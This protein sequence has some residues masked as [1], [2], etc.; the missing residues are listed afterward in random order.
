VYAKNLQLI[1]LTPDRV[2]VKRGIHE[3]LL[4]GTDVVET[5]RVL[6]A[7][8]NGTR[9]R[10]Q[11]IKSF[12]APRRDDID[13]LLN[14]LVQRRLVTTE[15]EEASPESENNPLQSSFYWNFGPAATEVPMKLQTSKVLVVG[16]NLITRSLV[17][18]LLEMGIGEVLLADHP[19]LSN[20]VTPFNSA[21]GSQN[22]Y[23][24]FRVLP[25]PPSDR[26]LEGISLLC[27]ASDLGEADAL[28]EINRLAL[29]AK[30]PFL[31][32]WINDMIGYVGPLNFPFETAC[33]Q[34]Y[35][36]RVDSQEARYE[37]TRTRR[38]FIA[39]DTAA[40]ESAGFL[41]P[42]AG[43][44]GEIAA[45]ETAKCLGQFVPIDA[46]AAVIELNLI[47]FNSTVRRVLKIPRCP[48]CS[49]VMLHSQKT[50]THGPQ[51]P[52]KE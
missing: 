39:L 24:R 3:L 45:M 23:E 50:L 19:V 1:P 49:D 20:Y 41:P 13:T 15:P 18:S 40:R 25:E 35:R 12:A 31:P 30:Q 27:A 14:M 44:L 28:L 32:I 47:S 51:I 36:L 29:N 17:R 38:K 2:L 52:F 7:M 6:L 46:A 37:V 42:M 5:L 26:D 8:L 48:E 21:N 22:G 11:I 34:C 10:E 9:N 43:I 33:F 4:E 16:S